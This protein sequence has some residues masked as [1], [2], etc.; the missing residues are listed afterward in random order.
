MNKLSLDMGIPAPPERIWAVSVDV[1]RWPEWTPT[2][3]HIAR[4]DDGPLRVGSRARIS[5]PKL[6]PATWCITE[7]VDGRSLTWVRQSPGLR[8]V[9]RHDVGPIAQ[10]RRVTLSLEFSGL[11]G[12][13]VAR[14]TRD[15]DIHYLGLEISGLSQRFP[16]TAGH[17]RRD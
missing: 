2:V 6:P 16:P 1:E 5:Q 12:F 15:L 10:G 14:M 4:L 17:L 8:V 9:A 11:L 13:L 7:L 3:T